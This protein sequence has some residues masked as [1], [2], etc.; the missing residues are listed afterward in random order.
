MILFFALKSNLSKVNIVMVLIMLFFP[1]A[2]V[3]FTYLPAQLC[4]FKKL[5]VTFDPLFLECVAGKVAEYLTWH[6]DR[7]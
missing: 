4:I 2:G 3:S 5:F 1:A 7:S 6:L